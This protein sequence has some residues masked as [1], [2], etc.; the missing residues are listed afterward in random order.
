MFAVPCPRPRIRQG[1]DWDNKSHDGNKVLFSDWVS[2]L[3]VVV[4]LVPPQA[5]QLEYL[6]EHKVKSYVLYDCHATPR[7][8]KLDML[9]NAV[10][11]LAVNRACAIRCAHTLTP[12]RS[13]FLPLVPSTPTYQ[14]HG[15]IEESLLTVLWPLFDGDWLRYGGDIFPHMDKMLRRWAGKFLLRIAVSSA[16]IPANILRQLQLWKKRYPET[17]SLSTCRNIAMRDTQYHAADVLFWPTRVENAM[18]RALQAYAYGMPVIGF[19]ANPMCELLAANPELAVPVAEKDTDST[20]FIVRESHKLYSGIVEKLITAVQ[21]P[22]QI[23]VASANATRF[24]KARGN[25]FEAAMQ[26]LFK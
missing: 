23:T 26:K 16:D 10:C 17:V 19:M 13:I 3:D 1:T 11:I 6:A 24:I 14:R 15:L 8:Q 12:P 9:K 5:E 25:Q 7:P 4:W 22:A 2:S 18:L 21:T 20:G